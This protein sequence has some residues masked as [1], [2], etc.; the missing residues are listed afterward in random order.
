MI[1]RVI[2]A[3]F[4]LVLILTSSFSQ[5]SDTGSLK[6]SSYHPVTRQSYPQ[7]LLFRTR[8]CSGDSRASFC[9]LFN[10][11]RCY[12]TSHSH[13][14]SFLH[15]GQFS[16]I[17]VISLPHFSQ[18]NFVSAPSTHKQQKKY[19]NES[20][21]KQKYPTDNTQSHAS[22]RSTKSTEAKITDLEPPDRLPAIRGTTGSGGSSQLLP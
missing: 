21:L 13:S 4:A 19:R 3:Q 17:T 16:L 11:C 9:H 8:S 5:S 12:A 22:K 2:I 1:T 6:A 20:K 10:C 7:P 15:P 14:H 18:R